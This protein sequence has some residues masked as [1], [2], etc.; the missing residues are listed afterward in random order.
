MSVRL[1][2][3]FKFPNGSNRDAAPEKV[4]SFNFLRY[5]SSRERSLSISFISDS[6][7]TAPVVVDDDV[8]VVV[9]AA[10]AVVGVVADADAEAADADVVT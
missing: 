10:V 4:T 5:S 7:D 6:I 9:A 1:V 3:I 2:L 8:P